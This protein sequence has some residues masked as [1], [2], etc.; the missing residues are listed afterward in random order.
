MANLGRNSNITESELRALHQEVFRWALYCTDFNRDLAKDAV[1]Q[2]YLKIVE[3]TA[4]FGGKSSLKTWLFGVVRL[5]A[6]ELRRGQER[7]IVGATHES[8]ELPDEIEELPEE[9]FAEL[10]WD[11]VD[12]EAV[13]RA[14]TELSLLQREIVY[15]VFYR[16]MP[17]SEIALVFDVSIGTVRKQYHRAKARLA[18]LLKSGE[19]DGKDSDKGGMASVARNYS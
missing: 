13:E 3:G 15:L 17:L 12:A 10:D 6:R 5:T 1:Q 18:E 9:T 7:Y 4:Y 11:Y 2:T 19:E 14:L 8:D 16:D